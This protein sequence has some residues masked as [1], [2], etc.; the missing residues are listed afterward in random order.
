MLADATCALPE[1]VMLSC[2]QVWVRAIAWQFYRAL[3]PQADRVKY[4]SDMLDHHLAHPTEW[5]QHARV[6]IGMLLEALWPR[7]HGV[8]LDN[9]AKC[10]NSL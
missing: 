7:V 1:R 3:A 4:H 6:A 2:I 8:K 5:T 9:N 10:V